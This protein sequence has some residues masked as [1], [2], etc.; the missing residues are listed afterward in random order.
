MLLSHVIEH[1]HDPL[2]LLGEIRR[3][4]VPGGH[5]FCAT[6]NGSSWGHRMMAANWNFL[7]PPRHLNIFSVPS[8]RRVCADAGFSNVSVHTS[9]RG[10]YGVFAKDRRERAD[11]NNSGIAKATSRIRSLRMTF[12]ESVKLLR[13]ADAGEEINAIAR[14]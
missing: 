1:V 5:L 13:D 8:M 6:P 12:A 7:D 10:A 9:I 3:V 4:M 11:G 2:A 14:C